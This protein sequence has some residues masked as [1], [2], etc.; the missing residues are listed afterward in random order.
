MN[1]RTSN[2]QNGRRLGIRDAQRAPCDLR[3]LVLHHKRGKDSQ[4][5]QMTHIVG[6]KGPA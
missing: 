6:I 3:P 2:Q 1:G 5:K 4:H